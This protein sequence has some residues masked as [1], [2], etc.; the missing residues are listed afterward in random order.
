MGDGPL[1]SRGSGGAGK[2]RGSRQQLD[3]LPVVADL[4]EEGQTAVVAAGGLGGRGN[5]TYRRQ[6]NSPAS[7]RFQHGQEGA[8][9]L[10]KI[11]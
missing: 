9:T 4:V 3:S 10:L 7:K 1:D 6:A 2:V 5:A 11:N 8:W